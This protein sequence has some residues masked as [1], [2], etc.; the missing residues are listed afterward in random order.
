MSSHHEFIVRPESTQD[1]D[2]INAVVTAAFGS[3]SE[4]RLVEAI[5]ASAEYIA[6]LALVA[7]LDDAVVGHVMVSRCALHNHDATV[8]IVMLSPLAVDPM[9]H[10]QGVGGLLVTTVTALADARGEPIVVLEGDPRYYSRFGF[11]PA[12]SHGIELPLPDWAPAAA[13]QVMRLTN[14]DPNLRGTVVY[15]ASFDGLAD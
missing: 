11:K 6:E 2:A 9:H 4:A 5:R 15:P 10:G 14:D 7:I 3:P 12:A 8:P 13:A 1:H